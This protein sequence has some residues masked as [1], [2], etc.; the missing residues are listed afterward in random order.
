M[1]NHMIG[2]DVDG[3]VS[4]ISGGERRRVSV[5]IGLVTDARAIFLDE[6]TTGL[7]SD[8]AEQL[9]SLLSHLATHKHRTVCNHRRHFLKDS[10]TTTCISWR[11][12]S[13]SKLLC[14]FSCVHWPALL[15]RLGDA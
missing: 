5:G 3:A 8:S 7:D 15:D 6:P 10:F 9:I 11:Y 12:A 14:F 2:E 1:K 4:G 13:R